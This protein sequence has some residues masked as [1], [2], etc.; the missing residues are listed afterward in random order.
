VTDYYFPDLGTL[1][2]SRKGE[3]GPF[4]RWHVQFEGEQVPHV[5]G[6]T[7]FAT[8]TNW[9]GMDSSCSAVLEHLAKQMRQL[10]GEHNM[11]PQLKRMHDS[12]EEYAHT[13][14]TT[15]WN[16]VSNSYKITGAVFFEPPTGTADR[17]HSIDHAKQRVKD[18]IQDGRRE[19]PSEQ[20]L[21]R[22]GATEPFTVLVVGTRGGVTQ[23]K[24]STDRA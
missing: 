3:F 18:Q 15:S 1:S 7:T 24:P 16:D 19:A 2:M 21:W 4:I 20:P 11:S 10:Y 5:V 22:W 23:R 6:G 17:V 14:V 8:P 12:M 9:Q 13:M